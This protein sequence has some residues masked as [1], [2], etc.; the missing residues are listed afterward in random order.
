M[1]LSAET[2]PSP[3]ENDFLLFD[4]P[5]SVESQYWLAKDKKSDTPVC[6]MNAGY[7]SGWCEESFGLPLVAAEVE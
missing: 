7:S 5:Y 3:D 2:L 4:P 1:S 6:I